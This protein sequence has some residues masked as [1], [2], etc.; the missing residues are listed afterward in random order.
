M[1][2]EILHFHE[3]LLNIGAGLSNL[4]SLARDAVIRGLKLDPQKLQVLNTR[5]KSDFSQGFINAVTEYSNKKIN[6]DQLI[7][8]MNSQL[9]IA[10]TRSYVMGIESVN[11][12][13]VLS[14]F[15]Y[16]RIQEIIGRQRFFLNR[17]I[18][19]ILTDA[20]R[21]SY[22]QRASMY[23]N[24]L[25]ASYSSGTMSRLNDNILIYWKLNPAEHCEDCK[26]MASGGPYSPSVIMQKS[27]RSGS[28]RCMG[29]CKCSLEITTKSRNRINSL[30]SRR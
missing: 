22:E 6:K 24:I 28:T 19:D 9:S 30:I 20:G 27:P 15:D 1:L 14:D 12:K 16:D 3:D 23:S 17:F 4:V 21:M 8:R 25:D 7:T 2:P 5:V 11:N 13:A 29:N 18:S 10:I 26:S